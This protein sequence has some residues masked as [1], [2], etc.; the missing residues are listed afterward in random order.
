MML[1]GRTVV[2]TGAARG[3]GRAI[4]ETLT[5]LEADV[6]TVDLVG[7][8]DH[9]LD[10]TDEA[11]W[12]ALAAELRTTRGQVHG[13]V[14]NAGATWRA[15]LD[16]VT[17]SDLQRVHGVNLTG[18]LLGIQ[19]LG[20]LMPAGGSIVT[21]GSAAALTGHYPI[22]Y[23]TSK[24]ALRGLTRAACVELGLRGIRI[25]N[26]HPGYIDT[27]MTASAAPAFREAHL[28]ETPLGRTGLPAE[29]ATTVA[30]LLSDAAGY[31]TGADIPVDG[32]F[33]AHGG[34]KTVS[35]A[36]RDPD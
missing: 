19:R 21:I 22:A 11:G 20:P 28:R 32:G 35:D 14:N 17:P 4:A 1:T 8:V 9:H 33:T 25:N 30:F 2:V 3:I 18:P 13:L 7:D 34:A 12:A 5:T 16:D 15:R 29:V 27:E 36:L 6:V 26:V 23:T 24:W 10:V 31:I